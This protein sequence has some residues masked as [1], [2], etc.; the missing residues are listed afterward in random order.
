MGRL[1]GP[2]LGGDRTLFDEVEGSIAIEEGPGLQEW[3]GQFWLP[4]SSPVR[5]GGKYGLIRDDGRGRAD[6]G[7]LRTGC[8]RGRPRGVPGQQPFRVTNAAAGAR[9]P[10]RHL[11]RSSYGRPNI[12]P[13]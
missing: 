13:N 8:R 4:E 7:S 3:R 1:R 2:L 11:V 5:P 12:E 6:R 10:W 9:P